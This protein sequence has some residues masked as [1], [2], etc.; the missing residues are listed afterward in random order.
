MLVSHSLIWNLGHGVASQKHMP[1]WGENRNLYYLFTWRMLR[2]Q[3]LFDWSELV[4]LAIR[5]AQ[6]AR[7]P[8]RHG[9]LPFSFPF[10]HYLCPYY[11][12]P[13]SSVRFKPFKPFMMAASVISLPPPAKSFDSFLWINAVACSWA[14]AQFF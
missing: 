7:M 5:S 14:E 11:Q 12:P 10:L 4:S 6:G 3:S 2:N 9:I 1:V 13:S 8:F